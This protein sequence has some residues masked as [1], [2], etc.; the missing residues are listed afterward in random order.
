M[1][2]LTLAVPFLFLAVPRPALAQAVDYESLPGTADTSYTTPAGLASF[3]SALATITDDSARSQLLATGAP[4][5]AISEYYDQ[6]GSAGAATGTATELSI[7]TS[8]PT[9]T[10]GS[11]SGYDTEDDEES[12]SGSATASRTS[13]RTSSS[14]AGAQGHATAPVGAVL[15]SGV[16][17]HLLLI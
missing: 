5:E 6:L 17:A 12:G 13:T 1:V 7:D 2:I 8:V 14:S 16:L 3:L 15:L 11:G 9:A 10:G 4:S